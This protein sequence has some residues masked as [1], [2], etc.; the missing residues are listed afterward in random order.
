MVT[1]CPLCSNQVPKRPFNGDASE[2]DCK[3]CG[4]FLLTGTA[5][6]VFETHKESEGFI[7]KLRYYIKCHQTKNHASPVKITSALLNRINGEPEF[8]LPSVL[9]QIDNL[10]FWIGKNK[11]NPASKMDGF[12]PEELACV[13]GA[14]DSNGVYYI[15]ELV[16]QEKLFLEQPSNRPGV[17][18]ISLM[19][20][21]LGWKRY[22]ELDKKTTQSNKAF[23]AMAFGKE[24]S[25][26]RGRLQKVFQE[27]KNAIETKTKFELCRGDTNPEP[28][29]ITIKIKADIR[30]A[31][32][33]IADLTENNNGAYWEAGFAEGLGKKVIYSCEK[34]FF[35]N[36]KTHF[37]TSQLYTI[38]W[39]ET[40]FSSACE[41]L[42][43]CI[44]A[45]IP[46]AL[47]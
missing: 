13:I 26:E 36:K 7:P 37:D 25:S 16:N 35:H 14:Y 39:D 28:G 19:P 23:M 1:N 40:N 18:S 11:K 12:D 9:E 15:L 33:V 46:N 2:F 31:A 30:K 10:I 27:F 24:D 21:L 32:F 3:K 22:Y 8:N 38:L 4:H 29:N 41:D 34:N 6:S 42:I 47:S 5:R 17:R 45:N 43:A 44:E 20:S